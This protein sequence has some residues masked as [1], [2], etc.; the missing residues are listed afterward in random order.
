MHR[1]LLQTIATE[2]PGIVRQLESNRPDLHGAAVQRLRDFVEMT[3]PHRSAA[4][5]L[6]RRGLLRGAG[7]ITFAA[8]SAKDD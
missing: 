6:T 7:A 5:R 8:M 3:A 4:R 1:N 2:L